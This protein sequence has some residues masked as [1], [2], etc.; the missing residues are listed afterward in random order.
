LPKPF[1]HKF[2]GI[3]TNYKYPFNQESSEMV[4]HS[5]L[6]DTNMWAC[7]NCGHENEEDSVICEACGSPRVKIEHDETKD[8]FWKDP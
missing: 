6:G 2:G 7:E 8:E 3:Y 4:Q 1:G 5:F